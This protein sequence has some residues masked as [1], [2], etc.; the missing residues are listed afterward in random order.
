[1]KIWLFCRELKN[2][3]VDVEEFLDI[4]RTKSHIVDGTKLVPLSNED[5]QQSSRRFRP[6]NGSSLR[7]PPETEAVSHHTIG[8]SSIHETPGM[9]GKT[10]GSGQDASNSSQ[11]QERLQGLEIELRNVHFGYNAKREVNRHI[12]QSL[13]RIHAHM[14]LVKVKHLK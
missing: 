2:S 14:N 13:I 7:S 9:N 12:Y 11:G 6:Q 10:F 4:L 8:S 5:V 3:L 1:M